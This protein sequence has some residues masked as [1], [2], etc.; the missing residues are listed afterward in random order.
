MNF[1]QYLS[2]KP[3]QYG[4]QNCFSF[5]VDNY[6]ARAMMRLCEPVTNSGLY[7][8]CDNWFTPMPLPI[9]LLKSHIDPCCTQIRNDYIL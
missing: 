5:Q 3:N 9:D 7:V 2:T 6:A 4:I 8:T 1:R